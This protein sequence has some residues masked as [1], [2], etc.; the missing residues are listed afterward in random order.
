M[1]ASFW[2]NCCAGGIVQ[3]VPSYFQLLVTT[4]VVSEIRYPLVF[5][6]MKTYSVDTF[7]QW[8]SDG[9]IVLRDPDLSA[10]WFHPGEN[11]AIALAVES[12]SWLLIDD[13][14]PY[15][16][17]K[18]FGL[19]VIGTADFAILLFDQGHITADTAFKALRAVRISKGQRRQ[20]L[21]LLETLIR[22]KKEER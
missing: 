1:D 19:R 10:E 13:A 17:A 11:A 12:A 9:R 3:F 16:R 14:N 20:A 5:L 4:P 6:G 21:S 2:I 15:H 18:A 7:E 8:I 22:R